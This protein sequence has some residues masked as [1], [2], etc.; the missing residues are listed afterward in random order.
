MF[1]YIFKTIPT[2][3]FNNSF[4]ITATQQIGLNGKADVYSISSRFESWSGRWL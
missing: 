4:L 1:Y 2:R 3:V